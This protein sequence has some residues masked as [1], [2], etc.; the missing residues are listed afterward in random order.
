ACHDCNQAKDS[1]WLA[2]F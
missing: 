1:Q 2:D